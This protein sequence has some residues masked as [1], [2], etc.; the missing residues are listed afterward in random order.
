MKIAA[1]AF[2]WVRRT[3]NRFGGRSLNCV[4]LPDTLQKRLFDAV[5]L[6]VSLSRWRPM[7]SVVDKRGRCA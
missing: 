1:P 6:V 5:N 2:R 3:M 7:G 4:M